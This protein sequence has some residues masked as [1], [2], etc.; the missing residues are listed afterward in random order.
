MRTRFPFG[1]ICPS[2]DGLDSGFRRNDGRRQHYLNPRPP[3]CAEVEPGRQ[4]A[5]E[6]AGV[7]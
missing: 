2:F 1:W 3:G 4:L 7:L 6:G 5:G